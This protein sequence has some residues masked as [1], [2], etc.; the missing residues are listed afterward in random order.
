MQDPNRAWKWAFVVLLVVI[1]LVVLYPPDKTLK[2]GIDLVGGT[3]LTYEIDTSGLSAQEKRGLAEAVM[4]VLK[5]RVDPGAQRNLEWRPIGN[6]RLEI[7]MPMPPAEARERREA[8][9]EAMKHLKAMNI[10]RSEIE[11]ALS[12]GKD[13]RDHELAKLVRGV[14]ERTELFNELKA[15]RDEL[16]FAQDELTAAEDAGADDTAALK[17]LVDQKSTAYEETFTKV[18]ATSLPENRLKDVLAIENEEARKAE[19]DKLKEA[20]PAYNKPLPSEAGEAAPGVIDRIVEAYDAWAKYK[21]DLEDPADLKRLLRGAGVL[22]F[23]ILADRDPSSPGRLLTSL[24]LSDKEKEIA[25]YVDDLQKY[26][27]RFQAGRRFRWF[28]VQDVVGFMNLK[29]IAEF[30]TRKEFYP[31][32]VE[33][34]AGKYYVLA[35]NDPQYSMLVDRRGGGAKWQLKNAWASPDPDTGGYVVSFELDVR[36]GSLFSELTGNNIG[37]QLCI[38]LD[39]QAMSHATIKTR[40]AARGQISPGKQGF[41]SEELSYLVRTLQAGAL[42]AKLKETPLMEKTIGPSLGQTNRAMGFRAAII[43]GLAVMVFVLFYYGIVAGGMADIALALNL[44][45]VLAVMAL[46]QAT[47]TLPGIA[48]LILTVGMAVD[49][50]VLIFERF[51][52]ERDRGVVFKKA[53][54]A[55]YDKA[56]ST[57]VDA[58]LT[59]LITC[60]I[61]GLVSTEEVKGFATVLGIGIV[62]SMFTAL[63]VTRL[64]FNTLIAKGMLRELKMRRLIRRPTIDW[65]SLRTKFWPISTVLVI[66][67]IGLFFYTGT[68]DK[69]GLYDIE[70][71]GGTSIQLDLSPGTELKPGTE[72]DERQVSDI[73]TNIDRSSEEGPSAVQWLLAAADHLEAAKVA[74]GQT[75]AEFTIESPDLTGEDIVSMMSETLRDVLAR[76]GANVEGRTAIFD[77]RGQRSLEDFQGYVSR[78]AAQARKTADL[79]RKARVQLVENLSEEAGSEPYKSFDVATVAT[80]RGMVQAAILAVL[81]DRLQVQRAKSYTLA[82]DEV[83]TRGQYFP[84]EEADNYLYEVLDTEADYDIRR[85]KGGVAIEVILDKKEQPM[86]VAEFEARLRE[87]GLREEF[88]DYGGRE[89]S[90]LPLGAPKERGDGT[91]GYMRFAVVAV[92]PS[93]PYQDDPRMWADNVAEPQVAQVK[94]AL[95]SEKSLTKVVQFAPQIAGQTQRSTVF[96]IVLALMAIVAYV[97]L[98]FGTMQ[99]GLAAIVALVHDVCITLGAVAVS[100]YLYGSI[101]GTVLDMDDF[102]IDL[103]MI[104]AIL[105]VI[106][107]SL[108]DTIVVFDRIRENRGKAGMLPASIINNSIN[109][110]LSRTLLTSIT[111]L[112]VVF[113]MY[114]LGGSGIKGFSYALLIGVI[115]GTYSSIGVA[116][117]LLYRPKV[118]NAVTGLIAAIGLVALIFAALGSGYPKLSLILSII[119]VALCAWFA[120]RQNMRLGALG[121]PA[122]AGA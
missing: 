36:G 25:T 102:K 117:P 111:T 54:N 29:N 112:L 18:L 26:G 93:L 38:M 100:H 114:V 103:P 83:I 13:Q 10:G 98:R 76:G 59:T 75:V 32:I 14:S 62:T 94:A 15:A 95:G 19:L 56:L 22:E 28:E 23:R 89:F 44:L 46:M 45:F 70:F 71:L 52:E 53:L 66:G 35:H 109:Q 107:Y 104:A 91:R 113:V 68:T 24:D 82:T 110:T 108:N 106:G 3:S 64:V 79:L 49:A 85:F 40:I 20:Y 115:I 16:K 72:P 67:G 7:R 58:N 5:Q 87:V 84:I 57:I 12:A 9:D 1:A 90:V 55:G 69:E 6:N 63:F 120:I 92:D 47:F 2:G 116:T 96:A 31:Q 80:D 122:G 34:Y 77:L 65:V 27:P 37:R 48:A 78:A 74:Q 81:G 73:I 97:W 118:L 30:E 39:D 50:N 101:V 4:D 11:S 61:L 43:G 51:R 8:F 121:A 86:A 42:P 99:F 17:E 88:A 60:V 21:G 105:T 119:A 41:T 33:R